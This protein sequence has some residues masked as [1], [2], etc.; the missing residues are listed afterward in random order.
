LDQSLL[1]QSRCHA[2]DHVADVIRHQQRT[3]RVDAVPHRTT[4][5]VTVGVDEALFWNFSPVRSFTSAEG[6]N[7]DD[8]WID[9]DAGLRPVSKLLGAW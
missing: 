6:G 2:P 3:L 1:G 5:G 8:I 7:H 9:D 4:E